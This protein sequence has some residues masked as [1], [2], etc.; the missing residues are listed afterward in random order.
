DAARRMVRPVMS[1]PHPLVPSLSR[2]CL[3]LRIEEGQPF[4]ELRAKRCKSA[5][6]LLLDLGGVEQRGDDG[7][8]TDADGDAGLDQ[9]GA[10]FLVRFVIVVAHRRFSMAFGRAWE[11]A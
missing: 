10:A 11:A 3:V 8:R 6:R 1:A 4:D 7:R 5:F 2:D 9:F